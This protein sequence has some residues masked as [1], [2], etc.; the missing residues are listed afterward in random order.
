MSIETGLLQGTVV[1]SSGLPEGSL[2]GISPLASY[3]TGIY[4]ASGA[5]IVA[6]DPATQRVFLVNAVASQVRVL[7]IA[8]PASPQL[9]GTIDMSSYGAQVNSV[10]V[11]NGLVAVAV[12]D[13]NPTLA[14][15]LV[16]FPANLAVTTTAAAPTGAA[17]FASGVQPDMVIFTPDGNKVL[18]A[19]EAEAINERASTDPFYNAGAPFVANGGITVVTL[20][21]TPATALSAAAVQQLDF[22]A[23]DA[24]KGYLT[25]RGV[26]LASDK[27]VADDLEPE[28]IA[29]SPDGKQAFV[30]LQE[31]NSL[32]VLDLSTA[33]AKIVDIVPMGLKNHLRGDLELTAYDELTGAELPSVGTD[34]FGN[35]VP[36]GG[37]SGLQYVGRSTAGNLSFLTVTDR[38][39][40][41]D[42][43]NVD[44]IAGDERPF[45]LPDYNVRVM[46]LEFNETTRTVS[47]GQT[48]LLK[49]PDGTPL[50]GLP[51]VQGFD[52]VPVEI[53]PT[54][55]STTGVMQITEYMNG[56]TSIGAKGEFIEFTNV[57][58][59][60][61]D[62]TGWSF[63]DSSRIAGS[64]SV[65]AFGIVNPGESV[66]LTEATADAFRSAWSLP[67]T[68]KVIGG[69]NQN[70]SG[71]G[72]GMYLFDAS[73]KEVEGLT[74]ASTGT[75]LATG[76]SA[77]TGIS[78]LSDSVADTD[79]TLSAAGDAQGAVTAVG[80]DVGSPGKFTAASFR[81]LPYKPYGADLEGIYK[82]ADGTMWAVDEYRPGIYQF[83]ADGTMMARFVPRGTAA[84]TA[85]TGDTFGTETL[86]AHLLSRQANRGFEALA[87]DEAKGVL[88]AFV[89]SPLDASSA[90]TTDTTGPL[91]RIEAISMLDVPGGARKGEVIGEYAYLLE[92]PALNLGA[93]DKIGDAAFNPTTGTIFV[94]ER[95]SS[96]AA[97][98]K[99]VLYEV[100]LRGATNLLGTIGPSSS[101]APYL[102]GSEGRAAFKSIISSGDAVGSTFKFAGIPD[103]VGV[104]D[105]GTTLR[106]LVNHELGSTAGAVRAHGSI[107]AFVSDLT[108]DKATLAVSA[109][110]D[111]LQSANNLYLWNGATWT[112]GTTTVFNRF[113]SGDLAD[114]SAFR[115][116]NL[117]YDGRLFLT[118]EEAG[119][120]GRA[121]AHV[122][123][124]SDQGKVYELG[125]LGNLSFENI[126]ANPKGQASTIAVALDD[127]STDGQVYVYVGTKTSAGNAVE[128]AGLANGKLFAVKVGTSNVVAV[129]AGTS[130]ANSGLGLD[131][132]GSGTFSLV[133]IAGAA[134]KTGAE[135]NTA[136]LA[137]LATSF[138][139][140]EDGA[141]SLDGGTFYFCTTASQTTASR[142]W[143]LKFADSGNPV[144]GGTIQMLL[145]GS[146]GQVMFDNLTV[147]QDGS[148][149]LQEDPGN[150]AGSARI[151]KYNPSTDAVV[152]VARHDLALVTG[153]TAVTQ[154]EESSGVVEV[155]SMLA[156]VAGYDTSKF[157]YFLTS[158]QIHKSVTTAG[159]VEMGQLV[160][161]ATARDGG[162]VDP[163]LAFGVTALETLTVDQLLA[164]KVNP[165]YKELV[166]NLPS[167]GYL[168]NDKVEGLALLN[169]GRLATINDNDFGVAGA[170]SEKVGLG[171]FAFNGENDLDA[172]DDNGIAI[173]PAQLYGAYMPDAIASFSAGG[174]TFYITANEGDSRTVDEVKISALGTSGKPVADATAGA[175]TLDADLKVITNGID[176]DGDGDLDK[177]VAF[178]S[179][180]VSIFDSYG[181]RVWD[182]GDSIERMVAA[183]FPANFNASHTSNTIDNRSDDKGP[184]PEGVT[185][186]VINGRTYAFVTL[187]RV[188]G[189]VC[190]DITDPRAPVM[191]DYGNNRNFAVAPALNA[192]G[193]LGPEGIIAISAADSPTKQPMLAVANEVS[194]TVTFYAQSLAGQTEF[195][196]AAA[197]TLQAD[198]SGT[199]LYGL[200][201]DDQLLSGAGADTLDGGQGVDTADFSA[202]EDGVI[203]DLGAGW[204]TGD[205]SDS[206]VDIENVLGSAGSDRVQGNAGANI[207][208]G[209]TGGDDVFL[210][211]GGDDT[212]DAMA[213]GD[214]FLGGDGNDTV[215]LGGARADYVISLAS[216]EQRITVAD[217]TRSEPSQSL[218]AVS[219]KSGSTSLAFIDA[220]RFVFRDA[221]ITNLTELLNPGA[222]TLTTGDA[223]SLAN[224]LQQVQAGGTIIVSPAVQL[225]GEFTVSRDDVTVI[226]ESAAATASSLA[227]S[228]AANGQAPVFILGAGVVRF[229]LGGGRDADVVGNGSDNVIIGNDGRNVISGGAG[230]D[231]LASGKGD[232]ELSGGNGQDLLLGG[233]GW[234]KLLG[235]NGDDLIFSGPGGLLDGVANGGTS[236]AD[237]LAGGAGS[238][239][240][241]V[242]VDGMGVSAAVRILAG[243]G[244]DH[245]S[246]AGGTG[247]NGVTGQGAVG[248]TGSATSAAS[249]PADVFVADL[250]GADAIDAVLMSQSA[251][252]AMLPVN[253]NLAPE[254]LFS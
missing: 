48:V 138:L 28:Y 204:A 46:T 248:A 12:A 40:N 188:G 216:A 156:G 7:S 171:V 234:D 158:D 27:T 218:L 6:H 98:A 143:A 56:G 147:A 64:F 175:A 123:T 45:R 18:V 254:L 120:E 210:G 136:S 84:L 245:I 200:G 165:V 251:L 153:S 75:P 107:G 97:E 115:F 223:S 168:P 127:S 82:T 195:G 174:K 183:A 132:T 42:P 152:D 124:G 167:L 178:G 226:L 51:N 193:D 206:L 133:E 39:P 58:G 128:Q 61:V 148:I 52:E 202:A 37:F 9:L 55:L 238:D 105:N 190:F 191:V 32:A 76:K 1:A 116:N 243:S 72:D 220:E 49:N 146:E 100:D 130:P 83:A 87:V 35:A 207:V 196:S 54:S 217:L 81:Y 2:T 149:L 121:F 129:E 155:S 85:D 187:E 154:D 38:G 92:R 224:A 47:L 134:Q 211:A 161:M 36:S 53:L 125:A 163:R 57:G 62:M 164:A 221:T 203:I 227:A 192:G 197:D 205:G 70:L 88:Y 179:R 232:D 114:S 13:A 66:V 10:A 117:G 16:M 43:A 194:G 162:A 209:S 30:T 63:D 244:N 50:L 34:A 17:S 31:A 186:A 240:L 25:E 89:Q 104:I 79:W 119:A 172:D 135:I 60:P 199:A 94:F 230:N 250:T 77:W 182:S 219:L 181:N 173:A 24:K 20:G 4:N 118:G 3:S 23:W 225:S 86:P 96:V 249:L 110:Q 180:S 247:A 169:D 212:F 170:G 126:V 166:A 59:T 214:V 22:T 177:L 236:P 69:L 102:V 228:A 189:V 122:V 140:P 246:I 91:I 67:A 131:A 145:D 26:R 253:S 80:G 252:L 99:K 109:G 151:W 241:V 160:L 141:W 65:S 112:S 176:V 29:V 229:E 237:L 139:R 113:C 74:Y 44:G 157:Q 90:V 137:A 222:I 108:I 73:G 185:T 144:Q 71:G 21:A 213:E 106:V 201:G 14:G 11:K 78:N 198:G 68:V 239:K 235:G 5:E 19:N 233:S 142:L 15:K 103:G 184:E 150:Y 101:A 8:N 242:M 111:F 33:T 208:F 93:L 159:I 215:K 41:L 95:D 231:I